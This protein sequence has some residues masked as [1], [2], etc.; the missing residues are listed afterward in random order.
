MTKKQFYKTILS[1]FTKRKF[2]F[3]LF[4]I[5][6]GLNLVFGLIEP[7]FSAQL[8]TGITSLNLKNILLFAF[9]FMLLALG[10]QFFRYIQREQ[11]NILENKI[12]LDMKAFFSNILFALEQ[13]N[14]D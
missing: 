2:S 4:L 14:F 8:L 9:L 10:E 11:R 1:F 5:L 13:K 3:I 6:G 7:F 12:S